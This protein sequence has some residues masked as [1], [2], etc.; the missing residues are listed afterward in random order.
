MNDSATPQRTKLWQMVL[1]VCAC[2]LAFA[3]LSSAFRQS[4]P[5]DGIGR[6]QMNVTNHGTLIIMDT[7]TGNVSSKYKIED[8][9]PADVPLTKPGR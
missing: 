9:A 4:T 7:V 1:V 6:F 3:V 8:G 5:N 2:V